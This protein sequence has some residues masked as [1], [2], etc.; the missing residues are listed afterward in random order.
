MIIISANFLRIIINY[1]FG[2]ILYC[3]F[4]DLLVH[5]LSKIKYQIELA[6]GSTMASVKAIEKETSATN[7]KTVIAI[8]KCPI[9]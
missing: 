4:F 6:M 7:I 3:Y 5:H 2:N 8:A 9:V 1:F